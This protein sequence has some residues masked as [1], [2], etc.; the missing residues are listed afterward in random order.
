VFQ[1]KRNAHGQIVCH[2]SKLIAEGY[3]QKHKVDFNDTFALMVKF[4]S[5]KLLLAIILIKDLEVYQIDFKSAFLNGDL[6]EVIFMEQHNGHVLEQQE[7]L[8]YKLQKS[9]YGLKQSL[10]AWYQKLDN[11]LVEY[12]FNKL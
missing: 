9:L 2:K 12:N 8:V 10:K 4:T 11:F 6:E 5:I 3:A 1:T 7:K